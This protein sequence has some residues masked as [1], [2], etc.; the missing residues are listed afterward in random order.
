[1]ALGS[2]QEQ[3]A[4]DRELFLT[5]ESFEIVESS[6]S[7]YLSCNKRLH[8]LGNFQI[9]SRKIYEVDEMRENGLMTTGVTY[10]ASCPGNS[11]D[12]R[13]QRYQCVYHSLSSC[14]CLSNAALSTKDGPKF[15][16]CLIN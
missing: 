14:S 6:P 12:R 3:N 16:N 8:F 13:L 10:I 4:N 7:I 1:M 9:F 11:W 2:I 5:Q 15:I